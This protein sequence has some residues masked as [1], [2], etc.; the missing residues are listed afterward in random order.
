MW[1]TEKKSH[2]HF[3]VGGHTDDGKCKFCCLHQSLEVDVGKG[4]VAAKNPN[5][6]VSGFEKGRTGQSTWVQ[7]CNLHSLQL[8][9]TVWV[10]ESCRVKESWR[11]VWQF[12][13]SDLKGI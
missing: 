3:Y 12:G 11:S 6:V 9:T 10:T 8:I 2:A 7:R 13:S 5:A 4:A 1:C